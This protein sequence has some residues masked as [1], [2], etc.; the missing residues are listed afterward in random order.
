MSYTL[1]YNGSLVDGHGGDPVADGAVLLKDERIH[2][3]GRKSEIRLPDAD[4]TMIDANGGTILPGMIDTHVHIMFNGFDLEKMMSEPFSYKFFDVIDSLKRTIECGV[5]TIRDAGGADLGVKR[6]V[7]DGLIVGPRLQ[8]SICMLSPTGGHADGWMPSGGN[9]HWFAPYPGRPDFIC[10][11]ID[12]IR[13]KVREVLRAGADVIKICSTGGVSSPNDHPFDLSYSPEELR[14][15][16]EEASYHRGKKV[17]VHAQGTEGIK[18]A[19]RAGAHS[20]E[21]GTLIDEEG[22]EL[23]LANNAFLVPTL[24]VGHYMRNMAPPT[25]PRPEWVLRT[26]ADLMAARQDQMT[27]AYQAGVNIAMGTDSGVMPHGFNLMELGL[28][29][30]IGM[31]PMEAIQATTKVAAECLGWQDEIGTLDVG[32]LGDVIVASTDPLQDI[33]SIG[34]PENIVLVIKEGQILKNRLA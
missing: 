3:V 10:D 18:N 15:F 21:H 2:A 26:G 23:M 12:G 11:G 5:T 14:V 20:I 25:R 19:L 27:R 24:L 9:I 32:K 28:M 1:V 8:I 29:C 16:V 22:I 33:E 17:M 13:R 31:S 7:A 30:G 4:V 34:D 6:A